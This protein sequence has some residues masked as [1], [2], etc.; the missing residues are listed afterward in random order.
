MNFPKK[1]ITIFPNTIISTFR[2]LFGNPPKICSTKQLK[3]FRLLP[4]F[5]D[6]FSFFFKNKFHFK[7]FRW[8]HRIQFFQQCRKISSRR[9]D[10]YSSLSEYRKARYQCV[11]WSFWSSRYVEFCFDKPVRKYMMKKSKRFSLIPRDN[12]HW[13]F[14]KKTVSLNYCSEH[15]KCR[16]D[17]FFKKK[18]TTSRNVFA[19]YQLVIGKKYQTTGFCQIRHIENYFAVL[20]TL[21]NSFHQ[22][23]E[24]LPLTQCPK[25]IK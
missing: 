6:N 13:S 8:T 3:R 24:T 14:S 9:P 15:V 25:M 22:T 18:C 16:F 19:H 2:M 11:S 7:V 5:D 10:F 1:T 21:Q 4:Q 23:A 17:K 20:T 12:K